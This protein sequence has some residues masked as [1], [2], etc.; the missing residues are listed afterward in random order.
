MTKRY[1]TVEEYL[2]NN[3]ERFEVKTFPCAFEC[4][5]HELSVTLSGDRERFIFSIE[6]RIRDMPLRAR[7]RH[8]LLFLF[9]GEQE[10]ISTKI[11][12]DKSK[13]GDFIKAIGDFAK[14][15]FG[16]KQ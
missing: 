10:Y 15:V 16:G 14:I 4:K 11:E 9:G 12:I 3:C 13:V 5:Q 7:I 1:A 2:E 8:A 6:N